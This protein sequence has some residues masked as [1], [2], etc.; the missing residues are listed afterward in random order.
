MHEESREVSYI[1]IRFQKFPSI[2]TTMFVI[3]K[4]RTKNT[5]GKSPKPHRHMSDKIEHNEANDALLHELAHELT[6]FEGYQRSRVTLLM[7]LLEQLCDLLSCGRW[8]GIDQV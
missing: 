2:H 7:V 1:L 3:K 8:H 5:Y 4:T 6:V